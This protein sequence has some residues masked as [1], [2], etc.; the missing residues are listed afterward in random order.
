MCVASEGVCEGFD[1]VGKSGCWLIEHS[2]WAIVAMGTCG[3]H[4]HRCYVRQ[5]HFVCVWFFFGVLFW[6][7]VSGTQS[8]NSRSWVSRGPMMGIITGRAPRLHEPTYTNHPH[9]VAV[10]SLKRFRPHYIKTSGLTRS[11][12]YVSAGCEGMQRLPFAQT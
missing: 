2:A 6:Q 8:L 7:S 11:R 4:R 1:C 9:T 10:V 5:A 12:R 3:G